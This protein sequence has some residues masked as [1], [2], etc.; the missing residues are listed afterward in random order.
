MYTWAGSGHAVILSGGCGSCAFVQARREG[1]VG[2][3]LPRAPRGSGA[4]PSPINIKCTKMHYSEKEK[5]KNFLSR[6]AI[7]DCLVPHKIFPRA[8]LWLLTGLVN[9]VGDGQ[10]VAIFWQ[11]GLYVIRNLIALSLYSHKNGRLPTINARQIKI[12]GWV[13]IIIFICYDTTV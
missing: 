9:K 5:F 10:K 1:G 12:F 3:K 11:R 2:G 6:G 7:R 8:P 4:P 13:L